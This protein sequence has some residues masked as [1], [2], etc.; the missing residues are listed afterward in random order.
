[1]KV[2]KIVMLQWEA[3]IY[4]AAIRS[5]DRATIAKKAFISVEFLTLL[6]LLPTRQKINLLAHDKI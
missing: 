4:F 5:E 1:M 2:A 6:T 3:S